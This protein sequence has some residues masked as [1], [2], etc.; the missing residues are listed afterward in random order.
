MGT[1]RMDRDPLQDVCS[2]DNSGDCAYGNGGVDE[3][4]K[5]ASECP[6]AAATVAG[7]ADGAIGGQGR[8]LISLPDAMLS[9]ILGK[10]RS[11]TCAL[12][13]RAHVA[14]L[15][16]R[17]TTRRGFINP[18]THRFNLE[19]LGAEATCPQLA[20]WTSC[21]NVWFR[22]RDMARAT[23]GGIKRLFVKVVLLSSDI[24]LWVNSSR[25]LPIVSCRAG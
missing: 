18:S 25:L 8:M 2:S 15:C 24:L 13:F 16:R 20:G 6:T 4:D 12:S 23:K 17:D 21:R 10:Q 19:T 5:M 7:E 1:M 14:L 9:E 3:S 11:G 22:L